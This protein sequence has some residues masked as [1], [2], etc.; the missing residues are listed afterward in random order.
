MRIVLLALSMG[1]VHGG[2]AGKHPGRDRTLS[3]L[4]ESY[5]KN[6]HTPGPWHVNSAPEGTADIIGESGLHLCAVDG[7]G[8]TAEQNH[9]NA[10]LMASAPELLAALENISALLRGHNFGDHSPIAEEIATIAGAAL[11]IAK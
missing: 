11:D 3:G 6:T 7:Y 1:G 2:G 9:A 10:K 5:M 4:S 8:M